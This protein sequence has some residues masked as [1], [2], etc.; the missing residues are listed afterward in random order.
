[1]ASSWCALDRTN[2]PICIRSCDFAASRSEWRR[3]C[4]VCKPSDFRS[5]SLKGVPT[6][7]NCL[8]KSTRVFGYDLSEKPLKNL[9][10]ASDFQAEYEGSIPFTRSNVFRYLLDGLAFH[11][12]IAAMRQ[13]AAINDWM[14]DLADDPPHAARAG[15]PGRRVVLKAKSDCLVTQASPPILVLDQQSRTAAWRGAAS[16]A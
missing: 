8:L 14:L 12:A 10:E 2:K 15:R 1:M 11:W 13:A 7:Q 5:N 9:L 6:A 4:T 16:V 3:P